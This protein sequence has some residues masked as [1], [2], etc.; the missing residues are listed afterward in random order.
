MAAPHGNE[1]GVGAAVRT[2]GVP[3]DEVFI[4]T[5]LWNADRGAGRVRTAFERSLDQ[6]GLDNV[7]LYLIHWP[8]PSRNLYVQ[9]WQALELSYDDQ[10]VRAIG[11]SN[12]TPA[13]LRRLLDET[14]VAPT[15]N[16][17]ELSIPAS[18]SMSCVNPTGSTALLA[19]HGVPWVRAPP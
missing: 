19:K 14:R 7:D 17:I 1:H 2:S 13:Q 10:Q 16:Q 4:T 5:K 9:T 3:R 6:P 12:F 11:V 15:V 8:V 18:S